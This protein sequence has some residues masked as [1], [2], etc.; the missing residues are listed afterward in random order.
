MKL[1]LKLGLRNIGRNHLRS[2]LTMTAVALC[3]GGL[4]LYSTVFAGMM[5]AVFDIMLK[6]S[7]HVRILHKDLAQKRRLGA[8]I[9][10]VDH[11]NKQ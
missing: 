4:I 8:G 9:Y 6:Q 5:D 2:F 7:G 10:F 3:S 1:L 11:A